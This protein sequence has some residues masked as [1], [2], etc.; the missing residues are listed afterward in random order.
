MNWRLAMAKIINQE[1]HLNNALDNIISLPK[2][3][4]ENDKRQKALGQ[5]NK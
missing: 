3:D 2:S 5:K 4:D 1:E